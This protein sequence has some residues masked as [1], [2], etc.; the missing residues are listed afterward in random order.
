MTGASKLVIQSASK[1][2]KWVLGVCYSCINLSEHGPQKE[3]TKYDYRLTL[4]NV[5]AT[6]QFQTIYRMLS[7]SDTKLASHIS[8]MFIERKG[9]LT[10]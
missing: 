2:L 3:A 1:F 7:I 6:R 5:E 10:V 9:S 8:S 4:A